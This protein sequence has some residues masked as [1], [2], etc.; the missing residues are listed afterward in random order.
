MKAVTLLA[1]ALGLANA[2]QDA[3]DVPDVPNDWQDASDADVKTWK[4]DVVHAQSTMKS[5]KNKSCQ[6]PK[7]KSLSKL[8]N[9]SKVRACNAINAMFCRRN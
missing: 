7:G 6:L 5:I 3:A 8:G 1:G 9:P 4:N 2:A